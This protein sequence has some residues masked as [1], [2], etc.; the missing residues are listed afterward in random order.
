MVKD[1]KA[2]M[3]H[4]VGGLEVKGQKERSNSVYYILLMKKQMHLVQLE[5]EDI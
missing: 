1:G 5:N 2:A 4:L 3:L